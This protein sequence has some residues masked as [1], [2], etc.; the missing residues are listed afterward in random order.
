MLKRRFSALSNSR[1]RTEMCSGTRHSGAFLMPDGMSVREEH[2]ESS[3]ADCNGRLAAVKSSL[4]RKLRLH[5]L[6]G[7]EY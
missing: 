2:Q 4:G 6:E 7:H 1:K 3:D 5:V